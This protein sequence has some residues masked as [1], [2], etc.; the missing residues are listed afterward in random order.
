M[1]PGCLVPPDAHVAWNVIPSGTPHGY[2]AVIGKN[3]KSLALVRNS[4]KCEWRKAKMQLHGCDALLCVKG[5]RDGLVM[6]V[7]FLVGIKYPWGSP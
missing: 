6:P 3:E 2:Y 4:I 1:H 7:P 5:K